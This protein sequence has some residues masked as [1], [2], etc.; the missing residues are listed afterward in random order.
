[1]SLLQGLSIVSLLLEMEKLWIKI[2]IGS[3]LSVIVKNSSKKMSKYIIRNFLQKMIWSRL[4]IQIKFN[5]I[6]MMIA[7]AKL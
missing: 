6:K 2:R 4:T 5:Q 3:S 7:Q 1:M